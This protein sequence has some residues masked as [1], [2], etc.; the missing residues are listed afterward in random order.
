MYYHRPDI[1]ARVFI[2]KATEFLKDLT[3]RQIMGPVS[4]YILSLEH[5]KRGMPHLHV[6]LIV[7]KETPGIGTPDFVNEYI[8]AEIPDLPP[9]TDT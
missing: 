8:C 3:K 7:D 2:D 4:G 6:L 1:V 5:Q 9:A